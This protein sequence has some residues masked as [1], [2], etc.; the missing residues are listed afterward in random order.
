MNYPAKTDPFPSPVSAE[1]QRVWVDAALATPGVNTPRAALENAAVFLVDPEGTLTDQ[2][3]PGDRTL[4][5]GALRRVRTDAGEMLMVEVH[6]HGVAGIVW[7][8]NERISSLWHS[9]ADPAVG[10]RTQRS[11]TRVFPWAREGKDVNGQS[12]AALMSYSPTREWLMANV[13]EASDEL[14]RR[15]GLRS[16]D[17]KEDLVLNGQQEPGM[18]LPQLHRLQEEPPLNDDGNPAYPAEY[19]GWMA[20]R[21]NNRTKRRQDIFGLTSAEVLA[22][23]PATKLGL[24]GD[25]IFFDAHTWLGKL[26][27]RLNRERA[28]AE[29]DGDEE[30]AARRATNVAVVSAH[31]VIGSPTP[32]RIYRIVQM[33]NRRDH[34]H[35]PLEFVPNDRGRALGRSV[36][37]V[38][39]A[40]GVLDEKESQILSGLAP[41]TDLPSLPEDATIA[42]LRDL[43]SMMILR[44]LFPSD[45]HKKLL[46]RRALSESPPSQLSSPEINRRARAWS[47]LTSESYPAPWN[48]RIAEVF[49]AGSVRAGLEFS[50]RPL[51]ELLAAADS[52][53]EAFE[54]LVA[55]RAAHWLA[56]FDIIDADRGSLAGQKTDDDD[57]AK[58]AR[59]RRTVKNHLNAL[60]NNRG[61]AVAL[62]RELAD[63]MNDGDRKPRR[64]S[65]SG[66]LLIEDMNTAWFDREFPKES[67]KRQQKVPAPRQSQNS[68]PPRPP[69]GGGTNEDQSAPAP[70]E[71]SPLVVPANG[72]SPSAL[73]LPFPAMSETVESAGEQS[74]P[75]GPV[76]APAV[77][78]PGH[79]EISLGELVDKADLLTRNL[80]EVARRAQEVFG[81]L[82]SLAAKEGVARP[83][84]N[85]AGSDVMR[86]LAE[87]VQEVRALREAG[88]DLGGRADL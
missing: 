22:G 23:V 4:R 47:A 43:R 48:P 40:E 73:A 28:A 58:A 65:R 60:R 61:M 19:V 3:A 31:L 20:V 10:S 75:S 38:Y 13:E 54:E 2:N 8:H 1:R 26:S 86:N 50:G 37:G 18:F 42:E 9:T 44:E 85:R 25:E 69:S 5:E 12:Y 29:R 59:V 33:S 41:I 7:E 52:D 78:V 66:N 67:G 77:P 16:Y 15:D 51:R 45:P 56:A 53:D 32:E 55:Y 24:S 62:L 49:N 63:A 46:L 34:V 35:P 39:V 87:A 80:L 14:D 74:H 82:P 68:P 70:S 36:L 88:E 81:M 64:V 27:E 84:A 71:R 30:D 76:P 21:G 11:L 17:L 72:S 6:L 83:L 79:S 57:G